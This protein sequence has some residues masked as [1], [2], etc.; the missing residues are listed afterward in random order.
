VFAT[1][2][3][4]RRLDMLLRSLAAQTLP[5]AEF[6]VIAVDDGSTDA[7]H[8]VLARHAAEASFAVWIVRL[9]ES[10]GPAGAR[11]AG[12]VRAAAPL[13][14]FTD[15]DCVCM[16]DW[17]ASGLAA[18]AEHPGDVIQGK[19][20]INPDE[21]DR[22]SPFAHF[23]YQ[24]GPDGGYPT[25]NIFYPRELLDRLGG[26][27]AEVFS[28]VAGE[29]TDLAWRAFELGARPVW[30]PEARVLH[31]VL[32]VGAVKRLRVAARWTP[33][34]QLYRQHPQMRGNLGHGLFWREN[35]WLLARFLLALAL[36]RRLGAVRI[37]LAAPYV[38]YLTD[39]TTGPLVAPY[40]LA[41]DA[42]EV[43][44]ILRGAV[45]YRVPIV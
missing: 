35:H 39:R 45:R 21:L 23:Y 24:D 38:A 28:T 7:T 5:A 31:G 16:P 36:P 2:N 8:E 13:V 3:R 22:M 33:L 15:D 10:R 19:V 1:R 11:N 29:D 18:H 27:D 14:A 17:L 25:A 20:D 30:A 9:P 12:W 42:V 6:E 32:L 41:V 34:V 43:A 4:A 37:A 44:A 26:F 40:L